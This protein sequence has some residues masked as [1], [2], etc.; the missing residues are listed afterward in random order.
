M[1]LDA[2]VPYHHGHHGLY[3]VASALVQ[4]EERKLGV[5]VRTPQTEEERG[6]R[7]LFRDPGM[8]SLIAAAEIWRL[9]KGES[10]VNLEKAE[11]LSIILE[12]T[13][14]ILRNKYDDYHHYES[15]AV[16]YR[17]LSQYP[18]DLMD[19][20]IR[21]DTKTKDV[22]EVVADKTEWVSQ[23]LKNV[24][25]LGKR[26]QNDLYHFCIALSREARQGGRYILKNLRAVA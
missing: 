7:D 24:K 23:E 26:R 6:A 14:R 22:L 9:S 20:K 11:R 2:C 25:R 10:G 1:T 16:L 15:L 3:G 13:A 12:K 4:R 5:K 19:L 21:P 18:R 17:A 8:V